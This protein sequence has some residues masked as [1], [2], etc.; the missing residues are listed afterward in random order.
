L[1]IAEGYGSVCPDDAVPGKVILFCHGVENAYH[2]AGTV[3][4]PGGTGNITIT[5]NGA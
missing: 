4:E 2:L 5:G 1:V 3:G